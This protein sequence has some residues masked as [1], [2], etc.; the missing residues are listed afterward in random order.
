MT[1]C[2]DWEIPS[3]TTPLSAHIQ[4][5]AFF[6][7]IDAL[8]SGD[9]RDLYD[10]IFQLSK[11]VQRFCY[12]VPALSAPFHGAFI[13]FRDM[14]ADF[15]DVH[16]ISSFPSGIDGISLKMPLEA[17][18][19]H[20][21]KNEENLQN[22]SIGCVDTFPASVS[23]WFFGIKVLPAAVGIIIMKTREP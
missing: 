11:A 1:S 20:S 23:H 16:F 14:T 5:S 13:R 6:R 7:E 10:Q 12:A 22:K 17:P 3:S 18:D 2:P 21:N 15:C 4:T 8:T 19:S 9:P